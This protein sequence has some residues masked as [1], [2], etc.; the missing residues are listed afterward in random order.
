MVGKEYLNKFH[1]KPSFIRRQV[2][3]IALLLGC[4][5]AKISV[6]GK[7]HLPKKNGF[8]VASNHFSILDPP[9]FKYAILKPINFLAASDQEVDG[10]FVWALHL[11]GFIPIDRENLAP[12][13][14]KKAKK[15]LK[16]GEILGIFPEGTTTSPVLK[17]PKNGAVFLSTVEKV[18]IVPISI[19]G[20]ETIWQDIF[21]GIRPKVYI[22]IGK[23]FGPFDIKG[24]KSEKLIKTESIGSEMA[25]RIA[26][27]LPPNKRGEYKKDV[28]IKKYQKENKIIPI[29]TMISPYYDPLL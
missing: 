14:I 17:K 4:I 5:V 24:T 11:Y 13:T 25:A 8:I 22:N 9:F 20:A 27:L 19:Y 7:W 10:A 16:N 29:E 28:R 26:S 23:P 12:S 2:G 6:R 1:P 3:Y 15:V 18:P 21:K